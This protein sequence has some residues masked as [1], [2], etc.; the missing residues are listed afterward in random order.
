[1]KQNVSVYVRMHAC[2]SYGRLAC[3]IASHLLPVHQINFELWRPAADRVTI[4][5]S[6]PEFLL[7]DRTGAIRSYNKP[8]ACFL[9]FV[10]HSL[11]NIIFQSSDLR[12]VVVFAH[13]HEGME[14]KTR[15]R[16]ARTDAEDNTSAGRMKILF[17]HKRPSELDTS[18]WV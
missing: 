6:Y 13:Y 15:P 8:I 17:G 16:F 2:E 9:L 7:S 1:M 3:P 11:R 4:V 18:A 12:P 5:D 14:V 10:L